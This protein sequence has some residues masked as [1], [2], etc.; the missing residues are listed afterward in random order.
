MATIAPVMQHQGVRVAVIGLVNMLNSGGAVVGCTLQPT[1]NQSSPGQSR[2]HSGNG[3]NSSSNSSCQLNLVV[4]GHGKLLLYSNVA[5]A[6]VT[7]DLGSMPSRYEAGGR[8]EV[9]LAGEHLQQN[10]VIMW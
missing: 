3:S 10:V 4:K 2:S 5:P 8:L 9:S 6:S 7:A 1:G